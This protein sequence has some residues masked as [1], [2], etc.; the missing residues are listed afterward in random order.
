MCTLIKVVP[1]CRKNE[2]IWKKPYLSVPLKM[3]LKQDPTT[4]P[5]EKIVPPRQVRTIFTC[6]MIYKKTLGILSNSSIPVSRSYFP[7]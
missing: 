4:F 1:P 2:I 3:L 5:A 7:L 6:H